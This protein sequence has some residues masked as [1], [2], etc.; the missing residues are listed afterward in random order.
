MPLEILTIC[1]SLRHGSS[2]A[3]LIEAYTRSAPSGINFS[4]LDSIGSLPLYS[5]DIDQEPLP[6]AVSETRQKV[7]NAD[8]LLFSTPEY[9]HSLPAALKNLLEWLVGDPRFHGK[10][11]AI[12]H[13]N[14]A[15]QFALSELREVLTTMSAQILDPACVVVNL[16]S[17]K[18][19]VDQILQNEEIR[20]S[21]SRSSKELACIIHEI[22]SESPRAQC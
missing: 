11:V 15:S 1:G 19:S 13:A 6:S 10:K 16:G 7:S 3:K 4:T 2:N 18:T 12:L 8:L 22:R 17:N 14:P 9:I 5:P 20:T 21:L